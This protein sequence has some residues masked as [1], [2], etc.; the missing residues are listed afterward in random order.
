MEAAGTT[1]LG[2]TEIEI[3]RATEV[4]A[5]GRAEHTRVLLVAEPTRVRPAI[6][7]SWLALSLFL[8]F[9][10]QRRLRTSQDWWR[11]LLP[12][13]SVFSQEL[14]PLSKSTRCKKPWEMEHQ[15]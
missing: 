1:V 3:E 2:L 9:Q 15:R 5:A 12:K 14:L 13:S 8:I 6:E 7:L 10:K 4:M 11:T